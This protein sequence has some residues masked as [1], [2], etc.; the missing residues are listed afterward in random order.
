VKSEERRGED[1]VARRISIVALTVSLLAL[2]FAGF[3]AWQTESELRAL[4]VALERAV[5]LQ[6]SPG[7]G[8]AP[9]LDTED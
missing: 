7:L 4:R 2:V 5:Q 1:R 8:P 6:S 3:S 9:T